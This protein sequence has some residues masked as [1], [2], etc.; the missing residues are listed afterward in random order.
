MRIGLLGVAAVAS[1]ATTSFGQVADSSNSTARGETRIGLLTVGTR[2]YLAEGTGA[3]RSASTTLSGAEFMLRSADGAG[4]FGRYESGTIA[5]PDNN[6]VAGKV[7]V[8]DG[9]FIL[10]TRSFALVVGYLART[11]RVDDESRRIGLG[12]AGL[13]IGRA[14]EGAGFMV[15]VGGYYLRTIRA[16]KKDSLEAD[17]LEGETSIVYAP[18][19]WPVYV[20]VGYR[21]EVFNHKK[22]DLVLRRE[23]LGKFILGV[24]IQSGLSPR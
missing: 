22:E 3:A 20:Q 6:P 5:G 14:F 10:G 11:S 16:A 8:L 21:R 2:R 7:E 12:R 1:L 24:G 13:E 19:R 9:R 18:P 15:N 17:G 23:E 4:M